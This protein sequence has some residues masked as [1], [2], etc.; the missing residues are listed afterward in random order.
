MK[1][2]SLIKNILITIWIFYMVI[3]GVFIWLLYYQWFNKN[4]AKCLFVYC[5]KFKGQET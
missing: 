5:N 2:V 1:N 4:I 3:F